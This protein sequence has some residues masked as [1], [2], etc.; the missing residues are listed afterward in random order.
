M[1]KITSGGRVFEKKKINWQPETWELVQ[2]DGG[3]FVS[4]ICP[5]IHYNLI[6]VS[7]IDPAGTVDSF[8]CDHPICAFS[9]R[10]RLEGWDP[11][12]R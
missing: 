12:L 10:V 1:K 9:G 5:Y 3:T 11:P 8:N 7:Q 2:K 6:P 4:I